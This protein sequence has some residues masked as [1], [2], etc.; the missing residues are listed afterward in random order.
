MNEAFL[1]STTAMKDGK[2]ENTPQKNNMFIQ[3]PVRPVFI[4]GLFH[5]IV[6]VALSLYLLYVYF[7]YGHFSILVFVAMM[8]WLIGAF[9]IISLVYIC[10][11]IIRKIL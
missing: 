1:S 3:N 8:I 7:A 6:S 4:I 5:I 11:K 2:I 9:I 10:K